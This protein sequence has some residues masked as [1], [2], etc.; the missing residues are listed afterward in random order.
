MEPTRRSP[1]LDL[2]H[3]DGRRIRFVRAGDRVTAHML[4][5]G[6]E[7]QMDVAEARALVE[8]LEH[9]GFT[10]TSGEM[11]A[12]TFFGETLRA[13]AIG[14]RLGGVTL[15]VR[16]M[17]AVRRF[18]C[19]VL[20]LPILAEHADR[21]AF[22]LGTD[23]L[24]LETVRSDQSDDAPSGVAQEVLPTWHTDDVRTE[25]TRLRGRGVPCFAPAD[26]GAP[27]SGTSESPKEVAETPWG[28]ASCF[29]DPEGHRW[30]LLQPRAT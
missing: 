2:V 15:R 18:Y 20:G 30:R 9:R 3:E 5:T 11:D 26:D 24:Y 16:D 13:P 29:A 8:R 25:V 1:A 14:L 4:G 28:L 17:A 22:R 21:A 12:A 23:V 7:R 19:D 6:G 27:D 10:R